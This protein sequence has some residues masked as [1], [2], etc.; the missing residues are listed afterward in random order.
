MWADFP[1]FG[2]F[3]KENTPRF[4]AQETINLYLTADPAGKKKFQMR[5]TPGLQQEQVVQVGTDPSRALFA[6]GERLYGIFGDQVY[7]FDTA[8][9][10]TLIGTLG[11][12]TGYVSIQANNNADGQVIF[13]DGQA[14]Y[15]Y[16]ET[17]G[18]FAQITDPG[19]P[20]SPID[21]A[22]LDGYFVVPQG[23]SRQYAISAL[24]DG[25]KWDPLD[26]AQ[27]QAYPGELIGVGVVNRRLFFF[28]NTS[29]EVWYNAGA[30]DFPFR[31]DNNLIFNYGCLTAASICS[32]HG[33]LFWLSQDQEGASSVM[34]ANGGAPEKI[35]TEAI[36]GIIQS[37]TE[38]A[39][40]RCY[41]RKDDS[42]VFY[43]MSWTTDDF[44]LVYDA[45]IS[46]EIG[47][48]FWFKEEMLKTKNSA[49][50]PMFNKTRHLA[51]CHA[52]FN[53]THYIG[54]YKAPI[55]YRMSL[56][57]IDNAGEPIK[58]ERICRHFNDQA[59]RLLQIAEIRVDFQTGIGNN[60]GIY[61]N[62][63]A[64]LSISRDGGER[65]GNH[66]PARLGRIGQ[67]KIRTRWL[68]KGTGR[69]LVF[70][71]TVY[72]SVAPIIILGAAINSKV[73]KQ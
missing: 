70:K 48:P 1:I 43:V 14:G 7:E 46:K 26:I 33:L 52:F 72:A 15:I 67:S 24:N 51:D 32:E 9:V 62:P 2:G 49:N 47:A 73:L 39:D 50:T 34:M 12:D 37:F 53:N 27:I 55:L 6:N 61:Q 3:N 19:F 16:N 5:G 18:V 71:I 20:S 58:R 38:P 4:D 23:E 35:S 13:V 31:R 45:T 68:K 22:F 11:T 66:V 30:A 56:D 10:K 40:V 54:S 8:L 36:D 41:I 25:T 69:D 63:K 59:Y 64:Y 57:Y 28:K 60:D 17:S 29:T 65:Y 21:V 44:T 42:H